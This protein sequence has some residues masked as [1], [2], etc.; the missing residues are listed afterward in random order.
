MKQQ[1][2]LLQ[3]KLDDFI[4]CLFDT[5][6]LV[7]RDTTKQSLTISSDTLK[8][9][10]SQILDSLERALDY[11][12]HITRRIMEKKFSSSWHETLRDIFEDMLPLPELED[13]MQAKDMQSVT[14]AISRNKMGELIISSVDYNI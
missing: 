1:H 2:K 3:E 4:G 8:G 9:Y 12:V 5:I 6:A 7:K 11:E 14:V 10:G 13:Y